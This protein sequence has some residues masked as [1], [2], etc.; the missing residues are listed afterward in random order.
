MPS[1]LGK[2]RP[3]ARR[4]E[5][6]PFQRFAILQT[7]YIEVMRRKPMQA[8]ILV[9][10]SGGSTM[11][12]RIG[13]LRAL[14]RHVERVFERLG[15]EPLYAGR[16]SHRHNLITCLGRVARCES[17]PG[18]HQPSPFFE[19]LATAVSR[20]DLVA[21]LVSQSHFRND[22]GKLVHSLA[23]SLNAAGL[24]QAELADRIGVD[25]AYV[26]G[27]EQGQRNP[28]VISLW[29]VA[30]GLDVPMRSFFDESK[31]RTSR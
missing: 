8:L 2:R 26:S 29:H 15:S 21:R 1:P 28:T 30:K 3:A 5:I 22:V 19:V 11:L 31:K 4:S 14:N 9:A 24:S 16:V 12:A 17:G 6:L 27:L 18:L 10:T 13:M 20:L 25:R 23:Q 7:A